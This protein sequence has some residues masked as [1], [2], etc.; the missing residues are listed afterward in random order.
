MQTSRDLVVWAGRRIRF[1]LCRE[2]FIASEKRAQ[3]LQQEKEAAILQVCRATFTTRT[4]NKNSHKIL[5]AWCNEDDFFQA[6][7]AE[8]ARRNAEAEAIEL[9]EQYNDMANQVRGV[10]D[11]SQTSTRNA[12]LLKIRVGVVDV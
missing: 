11:V 3:L 7:A 5:K 4:R 9:R 10:V 8:R 12:K 1:P 6:E 2:Q